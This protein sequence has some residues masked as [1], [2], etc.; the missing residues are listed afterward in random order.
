MYEQPTSG[1][2]TSLIC[3]CTLEFFSGILGLVKTTSFVRT[4]PH[5]ITFR[6]REVRIVKLQNSKILLRST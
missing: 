2:S 1:T 4:E 6:K 3:K 5:F